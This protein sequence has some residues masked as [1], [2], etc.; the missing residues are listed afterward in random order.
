MAPMVKYHIPLKIDKKLMN[1]FILESLEIQRIAN[2][3]NP[4]SQNT[5]FFFTIKKKS[6]NLFLQTKIQQKVSIR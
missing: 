5:D 6:N 1:N 4:E 2:C 3:Y